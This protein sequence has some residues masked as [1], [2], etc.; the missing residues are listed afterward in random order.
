[1]LVGLLAA[2]FAS[3]E[4][5]VQN[6]GGLS[7]EILS[8]VRN[9]ANA[10]PGKTLVFLQARIVNNGSPTIVNSY[11]LQALLAHRIKLNGASLYLRDGIEL[12][13]E[14]ETTRLMVRVYHDNDIDT[15]IQRQAVAGLLIDPP[16]SFSCASTLTAGRPMATDHAIISTG[17]VHNNDFVEDLVVHHLSLGLPKCLLGIVSR[18][19]HKHLLSFN[20]DHLHNRARNM[21]SNGAP[22]WE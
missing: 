14:T 7:G 16:L 1:L 2:F 22:M 18:H 3:R 8:L 12:Q 10:T 17:I 15:G 20:I 19:H 5:Y 9:E 4:Q 6:K 11:E 21:K 13:S